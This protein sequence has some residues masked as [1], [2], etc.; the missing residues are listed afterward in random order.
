LKE[1]LSNDSRFFSLDFT[2]LGIFISQD[3]P[4]SYNLHV[5]LAIDLLSGIVAN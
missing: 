1:S 2:G 5:V 4:T 3:N